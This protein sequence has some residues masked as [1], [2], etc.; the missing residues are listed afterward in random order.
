L[1][2]EPGWPLQLIFDERAL[3]KYQALFRTLFYFKHV[4]RVLASSWFSQ[5]M[6]KKFFLGTPGTYGASSIATN[7]VQD[8]PIADGP[9]FL[10][11]MSALRS[12]MLHF[13]R[14]FQY[15]MIVDVIEPNFAKMMNA[16]K[17]ASTMEGLVQS[18]ENFLDSTLAQCLLRC[19]GPFVDATKVCES[20]RLPFLHER[21]NVLFP[22]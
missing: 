1:D 8:D 6:I 12:R 18:H 11:Q 3:S 15:Y 21:A 5:Q 13:V 17:T 14:T 2:Y 22:P 10:H 16:V 4:E 9:M 7:Q 19:E 20:F